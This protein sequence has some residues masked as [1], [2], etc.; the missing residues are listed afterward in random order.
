MNQFNNGSEIPGLGEE[1]I[2]IISE[3]ARYFMSVLG[4]LRIVSASIIAGLSYIM[5]P[6]ESLKT[7]LLMLLIASIAD[8]ITRSFAI[9]VNNGGLLNSLRTRQLFS[10]NLWAGTKIKAFSYFIVALL[11]G[12]SHRVIAYD[13]IAVYL[14]TFI[15]SLMFLREFQSNI[16]NLID[17]GAENLTSLLLLTKRKQS[18]IIESAKVEGDNVILTT[19]K[20]DK[21]EVIIPIPKSLEDS[22]EKELEISESTEE[23]NFKINELIN[24]MDSQSDEEQDT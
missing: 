18:E 3:I 1:I 16:E 20:C 13:G 21:D 9:S 14:T 22:I 17:A 15:Y 5:F 11:V 7:S 23:L 24:L 6:E 19:K 10:K 8:I 12:A 2:N 4:Y